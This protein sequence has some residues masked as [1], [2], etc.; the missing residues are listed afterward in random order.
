MF[1]V[2][3][4]T[5]SYDPRKT[6]KT[7]D[8]IKAVVTTAVQN[9]STTQLDRFDEYFRHSALSRRIDDSDTSITNSTNEILIKKRLR[10]LIGKRGTYNLN[11][12]NALY[13]PHAGHKNI[14]TSSLFTFKF[15][16]NCRFVDNNGK[17]MVVTPSWNMENSYTQT[18]NNTIPTVLHENVG[19]IDYVSGKLEISRWATTRI[20]DGSNYIYLTVKPN[21]D[22]IIP[23]GN[24]ILTIE[25]SDID[26]AVIDDTDRLPHNKVKGY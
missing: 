14:L 2:P 17:I 11:F 26:V 9:Y 4:I 6:A 3:S 5:V 18:N 23:L 1:I 20:A 24:T 10:P 13:R 25:S 16:D 8:Q 12:N 21:L 19:S 15:V 22:D 7:S